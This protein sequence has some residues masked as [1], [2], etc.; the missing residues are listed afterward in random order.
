M[1]VVELDDDGGLVS[2]SLSAT[3]WRPL[4]A[5]FVTPTVFKKA[6]PW[7]PEQL[8]TAKKAQPKPPA[9]KVMV[10]AEHLKN[11]EALAKLAIGQ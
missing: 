2:K 11:L 8:K 6:A 3:R 7:T 4:R 10:D 1:L 9:G 5:A